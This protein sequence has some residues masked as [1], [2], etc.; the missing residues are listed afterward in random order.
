M[1]R[2]E[3]ALVDRYIHNYYNMN[4]RNS[5]LGIRNHGFWCLFRQWL[6]VVLWML[7]SL[8]PALLL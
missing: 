3:H 8:V 1:N 7:L 6:A 2:K 5:D 4:Y